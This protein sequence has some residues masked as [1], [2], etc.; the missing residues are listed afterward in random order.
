MLRWST[1][2]RV[3]ALCLLLITG[4]DLLAC[5]VLPGSICE[6]SGSPLSPA[7]PDDDNCM[8][9][10]FHVVPVQVAPEVTLI[11]YVYLQS[12]AT[13]VMPIGAIASLE[14]PPRA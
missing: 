6:L 3:V 11:T 4:F 9:C 13:P 7:Q 10:C 14:L 2:A 1:V 12:E 8:C 5:E